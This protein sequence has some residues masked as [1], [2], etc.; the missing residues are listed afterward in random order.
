MVSLLRLPL[1]ELINM[2]DIPKIKLVEDV[3]NHPSHYNKGGVEVIDII[4]AHTSHEEFAGF[5]FGNVIKYALRSPFKGDPVT[6]L[7]KGQ[8]YLDKLIAHEEDRLHKTSPNVKINLPNSP[9][10][11]CI[12]GD[13]NKTNIKTTF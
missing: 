1:I 3:V 10:P 9:R 8:W 5:L 11:S 7:K 4:R 13:E 6:D 2:S 12:V